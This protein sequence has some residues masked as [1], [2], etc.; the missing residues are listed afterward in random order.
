VTASARDLARVAAEKQ[1]AAQGNISN[2]DMKHIV[3]TYRIKAHT[4]PIYESAAQRSEH[5]LTCR[6]NNRLLLTRMSSARICRSK[7]A[8]AFTPSGSSPS[9]S[10]GSLSCCWA[11]CGPSGRETR[12]QITKHHVYPVNGITHTT[13]AN[14]RSWQKQIPQLHKANTGTVSSL[15]QQSAPHRQRTHNAATKNLAAYTHTHVPCPPAPSPYAPQ[16]LPFL[17]SGAAVPL[18]SP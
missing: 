7:S 1:Q 16:R 18:V 17:A 8:D 5:I 14:G 4:H 15:S 10:C 3:A 2:D 13:K 6:H 12:M 9:L 11:C